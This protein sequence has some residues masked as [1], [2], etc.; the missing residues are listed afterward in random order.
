MKC[1]ISLILSAHCYSTSSIFLI[2]HKTCWLKSVILCVSPALCSSSHIHINSENTRMHN[3][4]WTL[5]LWILSNT[6]EIPFYYVYAFRSQWDVT[7]PNEAYI[8]CNLP[9]H[10]IPHFWK[11]KSLTFLFTPSC[12]LSH[13]ST[14]QNHTVIMKKMLSGTS[15]A[16]QNHT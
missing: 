4:D 12:P 11:D 16:I 7:L 1:Y 8:T 5:A 14:K 6:K 10:R 3:K 9:L 15:L 2:A 13:T